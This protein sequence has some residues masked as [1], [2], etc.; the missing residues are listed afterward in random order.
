M[1][2]A[3]RQ[4]RRRATVPAATARRKSVRRVAKRHERGYDLDVPYAEE[5]VRW[6]NRMMG[7]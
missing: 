6:L 2:R 5:A 7:G 4:L 1:S 3:T